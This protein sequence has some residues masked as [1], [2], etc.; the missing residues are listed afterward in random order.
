MFSCLD[1]HTGHSVHEVH[2]F[3]FPAKTIFSNNL[4]TIDLRV[5]KEHW[6][7]W[8]GHSYSYLPNKQGGPFINFWNFFHPPRP[9]WDLPIYWFL[10]FFP[11]SPLIKH[12]ELSN[13][14]LLSV[15]IIEYLVS[16][17]IWIRLELI[18]V[19][20]NLFMEQIWENPYCFFIFYFS[21]FIELEEHFHPPRLLGTF[22]V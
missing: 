7:T 20:Q 17:M 3:E 5:V 1:I 9:Y 11:P 10:T 14:S 4:K 6:S 18:R 15:T 16:F 2:W 22:P 19:N 13:I 21:P 8:K 12:I